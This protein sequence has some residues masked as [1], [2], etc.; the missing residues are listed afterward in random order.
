M[1]ISDDV[2]KEVVN[3]KIVNKIYIESYKKDNNK[4]IPMDDV[5]K[6]EINILDEVVF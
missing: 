5:P 4:G 6:E 2:R 3:I 1:N